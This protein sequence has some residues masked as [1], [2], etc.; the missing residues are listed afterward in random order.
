MKKYIA[1]LLMLLAGGVGAARP[2]NPLYETQVLATGFEPQDQPKL[3]QQAF[4]D[5]LIKLSGSA[6]ALNRPA[7]QKALAEPDK[8]VSQFSYQESATQQRFL[9]VRFDETLVNQLIS[10]TGQ[11]VLSGYKQQPSS[12]VVWL[13]TQQEGHTQWAEEGLRQ[14]WQTLAANRNLPL[15]FPLLDLTD[16]SLVSEQGTWS[17]DLSS[18]RMASKRYN[19]DQL[20]IGKLTRQPTGWHAQWILLTQG[21]PSRWENSYSNVETWVGESVEGLVAQLAKAQAHPTEPALVKTLQLSVTGV[22][23][24]TDYTKVLDYLKNLPQ[25]KEAEVAEI[26]PAETIFKVR[27]T[28]NQEQLTKSIESGQLLVQSSAS[29]PDRL[30]YMMAA[31]AP[32]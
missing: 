17:E 27:T 24:L 18:L 4:K 12:I 22:T 32:E 5:L 6:E 15:V 26:N 19:A 2:S 3:I 23:A 31:E 20:V 29:Q 30:Y 9:R 8:Y 16:M 7:I 11:A 1:V 28:A 21:E 13:V 25:V 10:T 14:Q